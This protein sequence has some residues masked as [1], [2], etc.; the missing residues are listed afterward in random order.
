MGRGLSF[1]NMTVH[2][3][4]K[5]HEEGFSKFGEEELYWIARSHHLDPKFSPMTGTSVPSLTNLY[6]KQSRT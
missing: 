6:K 2:K 3:L 4:K 1:F 5:V